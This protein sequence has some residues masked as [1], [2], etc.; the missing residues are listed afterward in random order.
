LALP[1]ESGGM[2]F[3]DLTAKRLDKMVEQMEQQKEKRK[4]VHPVLTRDFGKKK[5]KSPRDLRS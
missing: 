1:F 2:T 5:V 3:G 4:S